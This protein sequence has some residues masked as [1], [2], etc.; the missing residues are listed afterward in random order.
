MPCSKFAIIADDDPN[1][2]N[3]A[4][5]AFQ[6]KRKEMVDGFVKA[7][8]TGFVEFAGDASTPRKDSGYA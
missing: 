8:R 4:I 3:R 2:L 5:Y 6:F 7:L 1:P